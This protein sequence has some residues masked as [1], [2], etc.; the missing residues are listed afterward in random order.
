VVGILHRCGSK[1]IRDI[2]VKSLFESFVYGDT[3]DY[4]KNYLV[5]V[6]LWVKVL[7]KKKLEKLSRFKHFV[8]VVSFIFLCKL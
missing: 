1:A 6:E 8:D 2:V 3:S 7:S 5:L 4:Q